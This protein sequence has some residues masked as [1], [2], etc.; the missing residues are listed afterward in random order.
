MNYKETREVEDQ[1]V[2]KTEFVAEEEEEQFVMKTAFMAT[3]ASCMAVEF[4]PHAMAVQEL[5]VLPANVDKHFAELTKA[6]PISMK[7][8]RNTV[9]QEKDKWRDSM[10][11]EL[12]GLMDRE[13]Y[14]EVSA[15][16]VPLSQVQNAPA[17]MVYVVKPALNEDGT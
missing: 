5:Q 17:R 3:A 11:K 1:L 16:M 14:E 12:K 6:H 10:N 4:E 2:T 9:N 7:A 8:V 15:D 13:T